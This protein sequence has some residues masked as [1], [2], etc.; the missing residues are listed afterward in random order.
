MSEEIKTNPDFERASREGFRYSSSVGDLTTEQLWEL[1]LVSTKAHK[2]SLNDIAKNIYQQLKAEDE[3]SFVDTKPKTKVIK[4]LE[5]KLEIVKH[6]IKVIQDEAAAKEAQKAKDDKKQKLM[7]LLSQKEDENM[8][9]SSIDE[10]KAMIA[11]LDK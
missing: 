5:A 10:I 11:D 1:S 2:P 7:I 9:K 8:S 6:I 3:V 4:L